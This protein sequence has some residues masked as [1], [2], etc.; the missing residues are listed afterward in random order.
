MA[1]FQ[2]AGAGSSPAARSTAKAVIEAEHYLHSFPTGWTQSYQVGDVWIVFAIPANKNLEP[3]LFKGPVGLRE[4]SRL[5]APD[6]HAPNALS[7]ALARAIRSLR[8]DVPA[9]EALVSFADP[10]VGHL[11]GVYRAASWL[12]TGQSHERRRY[13]TPDGR[14]VARRAFHSGAQS[15]RPTLPMTKVAGKHRFVRLLTRRATR[16]FKG[17]TP[18]SKNV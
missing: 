17:V 15:M 16:L 5:W 7:A 8:R 1:T 12:Y 2:V 4:L 6:N 9:C 10:N 11:G 18:M 3:F 13:A 14:I